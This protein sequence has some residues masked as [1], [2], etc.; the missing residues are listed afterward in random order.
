[1]SND[2]E[3][4]MHEAVESVMQLIIPDDPNRGKVT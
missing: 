3:E 2:H 1:M 4:I